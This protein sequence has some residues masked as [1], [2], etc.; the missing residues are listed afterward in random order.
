M[1]IVSLLKKVD[2]LNGLSESQL[3]KLAKLCREQTCSADDVIF[4]ENDTSSEL[5]LIQDGLVEITRS[6][7]E[8]GT[9]KRIVTLGKGQIFGEM[10]LVDE[11]P[12]SASAR[13][14]ADGTRLWVA[15]RADFISLCEKD[16][17]IGFLVMR[18]VAA[19]L[20]FKLRHSHLT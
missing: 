11:G 3:E 14:A 2:F 15:K 10:A 20:S 12:R 16:T 8:P 7:P 6:V 19:D 13:C 9:E 17:S 1:S 18:N 4:R 5:Y